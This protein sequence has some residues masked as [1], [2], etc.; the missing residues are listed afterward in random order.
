[1]GSEEPK[2]FEHTLHERVICL[3]MWSAI[4]S[5]AKSTVRTNERACNVRKW[6]WCFG[7]QKPFSSQIC[8]ECS[9]ESNVTHTG[10]GVRRARSFA[11]RMKVLKTNWTERFHGM[12]NV[13]KWKE[14][15]EALKCKIARAATNFI[16]INHLIFHK[17][18]AW[19]ILESYDDDD[20][21]KY[22]CMCV[23]VHCLDVDDDWLRGCSCVITPKDERL[24]EK[25]TNIAYNF[26]NNWNMRV[27]GQYARMCAE[28]QCAK[29]TSQS[30]YLLDSC[31]VCT[32]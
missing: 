11:H 29:N 13:M 18:Y 8:R 12:E 24:R 7:D 15:C 19:N 9:W 26:V 5:G 25:K 16:V 30:R 22:V 27:G 10:E 1:M 14:Y 17:S 31:H 4:N 2:P 3:K 6:L 28:S 20:R 32:I 21:M 23:C